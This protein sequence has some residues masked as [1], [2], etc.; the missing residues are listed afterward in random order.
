MSFKGTQAK[1]KRVSVPL[2]KK[3]YRAVGRFHILRY[4]EIQGFR[5]ENLKPS[6]LKI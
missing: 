5:L 2:S 3:T 1:N 4:N 6:S